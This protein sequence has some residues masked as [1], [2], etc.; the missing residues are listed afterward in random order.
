MLRTSE[1]MRLRLYLVR[2]VIITCAATVGRAAIAADAPVVDVPLRRVVLFTS[3][4]GFF[5]HA[6]K[7]TGDCQVEMK[8]NASE[9]ND[10]LKSIV[11]EDRGGGTIAAV[12]YGSKDP[13]ARTLSTFMI[14]LNGEPTL[15]DLLRQV[16]GER[17]EL[18]GTEPV[19]GTL[20]GVERRKT[21]V[22][23]EVLEEDFI[24]VVTASG[25][26]SVKLASVSQFKFTSEKLNA[27]LKQA[28]ATLAASHD[29]DKK[30]VTLRLSGKG[31]RA[32]RVGYIREAP[33]WKTSY[34]L[35]LDDKK[36]PLLQG[37]AIVE[38]TTEHDWDDAV[39]TL[40]SGRPISFV[41][42]L[43]QPLYASR[44]TVV[45]E[46]FAG[47]QPRTYEQDLG[48]K[49]KRFEAAERKQAAMVGTFPPQRRG[50]TGAMSGMGGGMGGMGGGAG[51]FGGAGQAFNRNQVPAIKLRSVDEQADALQ[52]LGVAAVASGQQ[53]G[54]LFR[55]AIADP[56]TIR[57][58]QSAMLPI[59]NESV[60]AEKL[61]IYNSSV[62]PRHPL[63]GVRLKNTTG[64]HWMQG[65]ITVFDE[66]EY[67]GDAR[68]EDVA[69]SA[70]RLI[71][72][73]LDLDV[74]VAP[75]F[76]QSPQEMRSARIVRGT[77]YT[78]LR[79]ERCQKY[80]VK[81]SSKRA[82]NVLIEQPR[83][84]GWKLVAPKKADEET[85]SMYRFR[86]AAEPGKPAELVV[87]EEQITK[88]EV[89]LATFDDNTI[90]LYM[91]YDG[92]SPA[93]KKV[94]TEIVERRRVI[95]S[96]GDQ[97]SEALRRLKVVETEQTRIRDNMAQL[98][99]NSDLY[100]RY[101]KKFSSQEDDV[102]AL[103]REVDRLTKQKQS[104]EADLAAWLGSV[105]AE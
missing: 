65:P 101:V 39:L 20:V 45:P 73:A 97:L 100:L 38:N 12:G 93:L 11:F 67:A 31:E 88:T 54:E 59:V 26:R 83:L 79:L 49:E 96:T 15:A 91:R 74:E 62:E 32:V 50:A 10:L 75:T 72:Y 99:R 60:E 2:A 34:R 84:P 16:R 6:G 22:K 51:G 70:S 3:G 5:E 66:G 86:L 69:P 92:A 17:V 40:V 13:A 53:V 35:V 25:L 44:P 37:W 77:V 46:M 42:D 14:N 18:E 48:E 24:N 82:R 61:S 29:A 98:D 21:R 28:L 23:D 41:M 64:L 78:E 85:R 90:A 63:N 105:I 95:A 104:Q 9:I 33:V 58:Q 89:A 76:S 52:D 68:I 57:R 102:D 94:L 103:Q 87:Q 43:Y 30:A 55:Y 4:V 47:L 56:V 80:M 19:T 7:V 27:D 8:F 36:P 71:S 1:R 81:N